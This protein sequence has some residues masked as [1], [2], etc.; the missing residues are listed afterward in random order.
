MHSEQSSHNIGN[1]AINLKHMQNFK[2]KVDGSQKVIIS[3]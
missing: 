1:L 2:H 3:Y